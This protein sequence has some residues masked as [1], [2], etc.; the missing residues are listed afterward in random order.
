MAY[1]VITWQTHE[2][3][4]GNPPRIARDKFRWNGEWR[5]SARKRQWLRDNGIAYTVTYAEEE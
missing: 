3:G 1:L 5:A 4:G 2:G